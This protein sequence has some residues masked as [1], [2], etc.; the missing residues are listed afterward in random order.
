MTE[1][2]MQIVIEQAWKEI[3]L[4]RIQTVEEKVTFLEKASLLKKLE[5]MEEK[6]TSLEKEIKDIK[7][8]EA[9]TDKKIVNISRQAVRRDFYQNAKTM[10]MLE[11]MCG[12]LPNLTESEILYAGLKA[13]KKAHA[14]AKDKFP[15]MEIAE[16]KNNEV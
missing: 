15:D 2:E 11:T 10:A 4:K 7:N 16:I 13:Y 6:V 9:I 3:I 14:E 5:A 12:H 8:R 1:S